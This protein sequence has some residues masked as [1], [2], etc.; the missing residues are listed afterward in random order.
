MNESIDEESIFVGTPR[1]SV[2]RGYAHKYIL[3]VIVVVFVACTCFSL[4]ATMVL[5][6]LEPAA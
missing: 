3:L 1:T 6:A 4:L 5:S 2:K